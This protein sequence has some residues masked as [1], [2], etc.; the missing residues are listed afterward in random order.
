VK[1]IR[2]SATAPLG[3]WILDFGFWIESGGRDDLENQNQ[4]FVEE[5]VFERHNLIATTNPK[6]KI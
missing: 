4:F 2:L 1:C 6:S 3:F 5:F